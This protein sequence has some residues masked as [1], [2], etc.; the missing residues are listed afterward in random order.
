MISATACLECEHVRLSHFRPITSE[1]TLPSDH[2][3]AENIEIRLV[4]FILIN[5]LFYVYSPQLVVGT[6]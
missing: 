5:S 6:H 3:S 1:G 2:R 4:F